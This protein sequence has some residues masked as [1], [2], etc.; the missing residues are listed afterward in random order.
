MISSEYVRIRSSVPLTRNVRAKIKKRVLALASQVERR[1]LL[2]ANHFLKWQGNIEEFNGQNYVHVTVIKYQM[3]HNRKLHVIK[4]IDE[5]AVF[6]GQ[7]VFT[8]ISVDIC[9][10]YLPT[11]LDDAVQMIVSELQ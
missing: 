1:V 11:T 6:V 10:F 9:S 5:P 4:R 7:K 8:C 2:P 3:C